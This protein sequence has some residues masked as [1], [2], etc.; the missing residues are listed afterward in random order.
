MSRPSWP[1]SARTW[2]SCPHLNTR[3][4]VQ[5]LGVR[6]MGTGQPWPRPRRRRAM[7]PSFVPQVSVRPPRFWTVSS[8]CSGEGRAK[9][10]KAVA[11][12]WLGAAG[13]RPRRF[14]AGHANGRHQPGQ[15][16]EAGPRRPRVELRTGF[17]LRRI[18]GRTPPA[19]QRSTGEEAVPRHATS[20]DRRNGGGRRGLGGAA[21][22]ERHD[23][24][25]QR[26]RRRA[27]FAYW[28]LIW[29]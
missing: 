21:Q 20:R 2:L 10:G 5:N 23:P 3:E 26:D 27:A 14:G 11:P 25:P 7:S 19:F 13:G 29:H 17:R 4:T 22:P 12:S 15:V 9:R 6:R 24:R 18:P 16:S 8:P 28:Y 1:G